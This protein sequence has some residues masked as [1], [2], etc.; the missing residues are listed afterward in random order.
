MREGLMYH[1]D[2]QVK[3]VVDVFV[4]GYPFDRRKAAEFRDAEEINFDRL[5]TVVSVYECN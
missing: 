4:W 5:L 1:I 3:V 2:F